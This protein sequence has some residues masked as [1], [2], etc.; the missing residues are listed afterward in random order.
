MHQPHIYNEVSSD[1]FLV[2]PHP[3]HHVHI[4]TMLRQEVRALR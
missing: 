1:P 2:S 4:D 3:Q